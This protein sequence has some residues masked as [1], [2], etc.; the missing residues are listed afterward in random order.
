MKKTY[1]HQLI[2]IPNKL[3]IK[4]KEAVLLAIIY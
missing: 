3:Y 2:S 4:Q 1:V